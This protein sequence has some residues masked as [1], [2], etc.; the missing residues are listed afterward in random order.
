MAGG[1]WSMDAPSWDSG[2]RS[3]SVGTF[4]LA[5][6]HGA[7][8]R[9]FPERITGHLDR[10]SGSGVRL[11]QTQPSATPDTLALRADVVAALRRH[12]DNHATTTGR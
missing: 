11:P 2:A 10:L 9:G 7:V 1:N 4:V 6:D 8:G 12:G 5:I 3:P